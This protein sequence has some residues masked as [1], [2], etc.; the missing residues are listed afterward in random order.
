MWFARTSPPAVLYEEA[1]HIIDE[2]FALAEW[3]G[4]KPAH[5]VPGNG[6]QPDLS[7]PVEVTKHFD[8]NA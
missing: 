4:C 6:P 7:V 1:V 5:A 8:G 3:Q 2:S